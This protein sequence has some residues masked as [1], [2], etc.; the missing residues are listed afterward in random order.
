MAIGPAFSANGSIDF[1]DPNDTDEE[2]TW[3][4]QGGTV[5][6]RLT[7][8]DLNVPEKR[9]IVPNS[10]DTARTAS[11]NEQVQAGTNVINVPR[12][13]VEEVLLPDLSLTPPRTATTT[14]FHVQAGDSVVVR[15]YTVREVT[16]VE[17][18]D[19]LAA[20]DP[21]TPWDDTADSANITVN[22]A[23]GN[24]SSTAPAIFLIADNA[25]VAYADC[26]SC[27]LA[28]YFTGNATST[29]LQLLAPP[30]RSGIGDGSRVD[31][32]PNDEFLSGNDIRF[33]LVDGNAAPV[34]AGA[35]VSVGPDGYV[36]ITGT[37][38]TV[39][40]QYCFCLVLGF[41]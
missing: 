6:I 16:N 1:Y 37:G 4:N 30:I 24:R 11:T 10:S 3:T 15:G 23:F 12:S 29:T 5:G 19:A 40:D 25:G 22:V 36:S 26:P 14:V 17:N 2:Q 38:G 13:F 39:P 41:G 28:E 18:L 32:D 20:D 7:D 33:V 21:D 31:G 34:A 8:D 9:V 27:A 35:R